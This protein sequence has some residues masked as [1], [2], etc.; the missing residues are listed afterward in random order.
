MPD[1]AALV[2]ESHRISLELTNAPTLDEL[3]RSIVKAGIERLD[4]DRLGLLLYDP[5]TEM[6]RGTWGIDNQGQLVDET[7]YLARLDHN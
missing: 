7:G 2:I 3:Y 1:F 5:D 4:F 6:V